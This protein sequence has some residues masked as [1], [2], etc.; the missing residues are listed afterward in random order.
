V[1]ACGTIFDWRLIDRVRVV[2]RKTPLDI[3]EPLGER[4]QTPAERLA[5]KDRYEAALRQ[6]QARDFTGAIEGFQTLATSGDAAVGLAIRRCQA[7]LSIPP[8]E[9]WDGVT[10]LTRK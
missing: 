4:G 2:G 3:F 6:F 8:S 5:L 1:K 10:D 7:A 9:N